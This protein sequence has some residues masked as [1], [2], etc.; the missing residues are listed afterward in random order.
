MSSYVRVPPKDIGMRL[1]RWLRTRLPSLPQ[2]IICRLI[3]KQAIAVSRKQ[4]TFGAAAPTTEWTAMP[5]EIS[6][7]LETGAFVMLPANLANEAVL[8]GVMHIFSALSILLACFSGCSFRA[9]VTT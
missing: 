5:T 4:T 9:F 3:R 1:D 6:T 2:S 7:R 8:L